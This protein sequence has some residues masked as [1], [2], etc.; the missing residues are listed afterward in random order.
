LVLRRRDDGSVNGVYVRRLKDKLGT[1]SMASAEVDFQDAWALPVGDFRRVVQVVLNTSRLYNA[2]VSCGIIQRAWREAHADAT[3][4]T[5]FGQPILA[6]P[7]IARIVT[8]LRTEAYAARGLAHPAP[9]RAPR[10]GRARQDHGRAG[11]RCG[12]WST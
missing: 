2:A 10:R 5:A 9:G 4:R 7:S 8:R 1:R 3:H 6:F 11:A 12:C